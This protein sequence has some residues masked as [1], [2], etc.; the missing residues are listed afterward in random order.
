MILYIF[1]VLNTYMMS[2]MVK[3]RYF[4]EIY[5]IFLIT[6]YH[7]YKINN[8]HDCCT[9]KISKI[10][11]LGEEEIIIEST[12]IKPFKN[13]LFYGCIICGKYHFCETSKK[14]CPLIV[15]N[16][17]NVCIYSGKVVS[18]VDMV[19]GKFSD[20]Q[21]FSNEAII[22]KDRKKDVILKKRS[23]PN[24]NGNKIDYYGNNNTNNNNNMNYK[25]QNN[26]ANKV[27]LLS[28]INKKEKNDNQA[29]VDKMKF[30]MK[31]G[32]K[33]DMDIDNN[34]SQQ[35]HNQQQQQQQIKDFYD[36]DLKES[37]ESKECDGIDSL[38]NNI[39][40][41]LSIDSKRI[42]NKYFF[43]IE[44]FIKKIYKPEICKRNNCKKKKIQYNEIISSSSS[45]SFSNL[46]INN[47]F[48]QIF[49]QKIHQEIENIKVLCNNIDNILLKFQKNIKSIKYEINHKEF[50]QVIYKIIGLVYNSPF[51]Y[52]LIIEFIDKSKEK[53]IN[54]SKKIS[55]LGIDH[56]MI[57]ALKIID[58]S[59]I[60]NSLI[61]DL[62]TENF[63]MSDFQ[64]FNILIWGKVNWLI[65][66]KTNEWIL[67]NYLGKLNESIHY[68]S[69]FYSDF[70]KNSNLIISCLK[71]Y[72]NSP[73]WI[74]NELF[75]VK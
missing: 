16:E 56:S 44:D 29:I 27:L 34:P 4:Y 63:F 60:C 43:F 48:F 14:N 55:K 71:S 53:D 18:N 59:K 6:R 52:N 50:N 26:L 13:E 21:N 35:Q 42:L 23:M 67:L 5:W 46:C 75:F 31:R 54:Y 41:P 72:N 39:I 32:I 73:L 9:K 8:F 25:K 11:K 51:M 37:K 65:D 68:K 7:I 57:I 40:N 64:G 10:N 17:H 24:I 30:K 22:I 15:T 1:F 49:D 28:S 61:C 33:N 38:E 69:I 58:I 47:G 62:F 2:N 36:F 20:E 3:D 70:T 12:I 45:L 66:K 19:M 74:K